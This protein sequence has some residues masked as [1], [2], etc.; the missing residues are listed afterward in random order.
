MNHLVLYYL[1]YYNSIVKK[2][3]SFTV[4]MEIILEKCAEQNYQKMFVL[5]IRKVWMGKWY[6]KYRQIGTI[7]EY[8]VWVV[9]D[10]RKKLSQ[11]AFDVAGRNN[12]CPLMNAGCVM[13]TYLQYYVIKMHLA[14]CVSTV[15]R[16]TSMKITTVTI[17]GKYT[18]LIMIIII[19]LMII[20]NNNNNDSNDHLTRIQ[21]K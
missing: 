1:L 13:V 6:E 9:I 4:F 12:R 10:N 2:Y 14:H 19:I 21:L 20:I 5:P 7:F 18:L 8:V 15:L 16:Q 11:E 3:S 17:H